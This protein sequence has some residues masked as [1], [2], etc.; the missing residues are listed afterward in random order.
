MHINN[1]HKDISKIEYYLKYL[2]NNIFSKCEMCE[3]EKYL[4]IKK[5]IKI[6]Q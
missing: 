2:N 3:V 1:H 6:L 4:W 5:D